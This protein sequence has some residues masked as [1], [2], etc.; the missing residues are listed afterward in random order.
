MIQLLKWKKIDESVYRR[1]VLSCLL[2][3]SMTVGTF[4]VIKAIYSC[5]SLKSQ[6]FKG[7]EVVVLCDHS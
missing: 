4:P 3:L 7:N 6:K 5:E 1:P 2:F